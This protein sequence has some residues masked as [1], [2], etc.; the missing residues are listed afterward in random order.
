MRLIWSFSAQVTETI[1]VRGVNEQ[2]FE[3]FAPPH[4]ER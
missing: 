1:D 4:Y 3:G 2:F